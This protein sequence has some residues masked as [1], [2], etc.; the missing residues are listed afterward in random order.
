MDQ[1]RFPDS[2]IP[3]IQSLEELFKAK[4]IAAIIGIA[5]RLVTFWRT[6]HGLPYI[7]LG[8]QAYFSKT[9]VVAF[10]N[11]YQKNVPDKVAILGRQLAERART[12]RLA[13]YKK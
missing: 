3:E 6:E 9:Q 4:E 5:P 10:L 1:N 8:K 12:V 13:R 7:R 11:Y 2:E